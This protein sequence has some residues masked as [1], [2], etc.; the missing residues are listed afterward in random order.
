M[1]CILDTNIIS[2]LIK[3]DPD[4]H[5]VSFIDSL[6]E[7]NIFLSV[8]T[9]GEIQFGIQKLPQSKKRGRILSWLETDLLAR[10]ENRIVE[11][12]IETMLMWGEMNAS[13]QALG[14]PM[15]IMDSLIAATCKTKQYTL[16]TRNTKDFLHLDIVLIDPFSV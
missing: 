3:Q 6:P 7:E 2:E 8:V 16:I 11:I 1:N 9:I 13:L 10:F 5:I 12:D 15:P 14:T 4:H